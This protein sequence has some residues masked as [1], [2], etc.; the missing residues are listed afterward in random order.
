ME[1]NCFKTNRF[2]CNCSKNA[3]TLCKRKND[4][5][6]NWVTEAFEY[7]NSEIKILWSSSI[8]KTQPKAQDGLVFFKY[9]GEAI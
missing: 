6:I 1:A 8:Y 2:I 9:D 3:T 4:K 5:M 7:S